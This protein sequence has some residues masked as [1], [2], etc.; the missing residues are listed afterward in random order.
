M[1]FKNAAVKEINDRVGHKN[2]SVSTIHDFLWDNIKHFQKELKMA[3]VALANDDLVEKIKID[4]PNPVPEGFFDSCEEGIQYKEYLKLS[5]GI[6]SHDELLIVA[7]Y[8]FE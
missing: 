6:I 3:L 8:L 2:L 4:E 1:T 7:N 5:K